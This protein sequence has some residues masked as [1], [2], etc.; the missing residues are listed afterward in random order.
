MSP[1]NHKQIFWPFSSISS[2]TPAEP[3]IDLLRG[4]EQHAEWVQTPNI[5]H[6][7]E[8]VCNFFRVLFCITLDRSFAALCAFLL[9]TPHPTLEFAPS[10]VSSNFPG[11]LLRAWQRSVLHTLALS[12]WVNCPHDQYV[13]AKEVP[14][15]HFVGRIENSNCVHTTP[16]ACP[17]TT[18]N[19]K[20]ISNR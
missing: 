14:H 11:R 3:R 6:T 16:H 20:A 17:D 1:E 10:R 12:G 5:I 13:R 19:P 2:E 18:R 4:N 9:Q 8:H 7:F 15:P